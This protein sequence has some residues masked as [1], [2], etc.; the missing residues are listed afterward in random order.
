MTKEAYREELAAAHARIAQLEAQLAERTETRDPKVAKLEQ[1]RATIVRTS[2]PRYLR[3]FT[4]GIIGGT[5]LAFAAIGLV[6]WLAAGALPGEIGLIFGIG[7]MGLFFGL[8]IGLLQFFLTPLTAKRQLE[9]IDQALA[10]ARRIAKLESEVA[11]M[12]R[13][14]VAS[15][16]SAEPEEDETVTAE[17]RRRTGP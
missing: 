8:L 14:R 6:A 9:A 16:P 2:Q 5:T 15:E 3:N 1:Q 11:E 13:V 7:G 12:R 4:L 17:E 10:E